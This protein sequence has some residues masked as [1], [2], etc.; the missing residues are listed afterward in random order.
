[1]R[2][3][4]KRRMATWALVAA[5]TATAGWGCDKIGENSA[6]QKDRD[7]NTHLAESKASRE[8]GGEAGMKGSTSA[9]QAAAGISG[10]TGAATAQ[11]KSALARDEVDRA[12]AMLPEIERRSLQMRQALWEIREAGNKIAAI[13][14][15][16][17]AFGQLE[18]K[19]ALAQ[20]ETDRAAI[21]AQLD[22]AKTLADGYKGDL[23]KRQAEIAQ[24]KGE[25]EK[26]ETEAEGLTEKSAAAKGDEAMKQFRAATDARIKAGTLAAEIE[27]KNAATM[28]V[29]RNLAMAQQRLQFWQ[30]ANK[31]LDERQQQLGTNWNETK[32]QIEA[33]TQTAAKVAATVITPNGDK[34]HPNAGARLE[35]LGAENDKKRGEVVKLLNDAIQHFDEAAGAADKY[36]NEVQARIS[37]I[38]QKNP[39]APEL[40]ALRGLT[41]LYDKNPYLLEKGVAQNLK[42]DL[43]ADKAAELQQAADAKK[44]LATFAPDAKLPPRLAGA[45]ADAA[46]NEAKEAYKAAEAT[47]QPVAEASTNVDNLTL[48]KNAGR[49]ALAHAHLGRYML[50]SHEEDARVALKADV[51]QAQEANID[52][53][54]A[55]EALSKSANK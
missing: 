25:R 9:L 16:G 35:N 29:Q 21:K 37:E 14:Q 24:L 27:T 32:G 7:V 8:K 20:V 28:P 30:N 1:M 38:S 3:T 36:H 39:N 19:E 53:R 47:L 15:T 6:R 2:Y 46:Y 34:D 41:G 17:A 54:L 12:T 18:P 26:F 50:P 40:A 52:L 44:E 31:E 42:A 22:A 10:A 45:S 23:D 33:E 48:V 4:G 11:A 43:L 13:R 5:A 51:D 49:V 55:R